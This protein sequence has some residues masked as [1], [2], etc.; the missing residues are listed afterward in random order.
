MDIRSAYAVRL[1]SL[2][3]DKLC[4]GHPGPDAEVATR[5]ED[6]NIIVKT[7]FAICCNDE[8]GGVGDHQTFDN[9]MD[10]IDAAL[11]LS[12]D[13]RELD[14]YV[15]FTMSCGTDQWIP[16]KHVAMPRV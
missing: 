6:E 1:G 9:V 16:V 2:L 3:A 10:A 15:G 14:V 12:D 4:H 13:P 5:D 7:D 8:S 11:L